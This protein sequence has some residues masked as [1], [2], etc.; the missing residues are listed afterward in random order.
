MPKP[1]SKRRSG[2]TYFIDFIVYRVRR[3]YVVDTLHMYYHSNSSVTVAVRQANFM[4]KLR[5]DGQQL[6][7]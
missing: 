7:R 6:C 2:V 5:F 1:L 4:T 3:I